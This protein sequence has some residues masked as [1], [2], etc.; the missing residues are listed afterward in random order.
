MRG[1]WAKS[2]AVAIAA[3][4]ALALGGSPAQAAT[5]IGATV[6]GLTPAATTVVT[7]LQQSLGSLGCISP[8]LGQTFRPW[9]DYDWYYPL[10]GGDMESDLYWNRGWGT[11]FV[12]DNET[13]YVN[14]NSANRRSLE[15][16]S[17][18][19]ASITSN[20][21][22][23]AMKF[24]LFMK[25]PNTIGS[26]LTI[27]VTARDPLTGATK[28]VSW[29]Y[30]ADGRTNWLLSAGLAGGHD[31][32]ILPEQAGSSLLQ[33]ITVTVSVSGGGSWRVDDFYVD[34]WRST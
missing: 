11:K 24:R 12:Y 34:P 28:N 26:K 32:P 33:T 5:P 7:P 19:S 20:C 31:G 16:G 13:R 10:G 17:G 27:K 30:G 8:A 29:S 4:G 9:N 14:S 3:V 22:P 18:S 6:D 23:A 25:A 15:I 21:V 2:M 1:R